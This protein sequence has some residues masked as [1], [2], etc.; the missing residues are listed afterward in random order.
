MLSSLGLLSTAPDGGDAQ[1]VRPALSGGGGGGGCPGGSVR[2]TAGGGAGGSPR[3]L[4]TPVADHS[5]PLPLTGQ[6][7]ARCV[8]FLGW[9]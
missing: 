1:L 6:P 7:P 2:S 3:L 9:P 5:S 8:S 4:S